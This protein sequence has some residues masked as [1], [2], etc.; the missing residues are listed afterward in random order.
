MATQSNPDDDSDHVR[1]D[2]ESDC[3]HSFNKAG[4]PSNYTSSTSNH[5]L[6]IQEGD[7][8]H[9]GHRS[10]LNEPSKPISEDNRIASDT[11]DVEETEDDEDELMVPSKHLANCQKAR[12]QLTSRNKTENTKAGE[13]HLANIY[14]ERLPKLE[15]PALENTSSP[16]TATLKAMSEILSWTRST[17]SEDLPYPGQQLPTSPVS[18]HPL[19]LS[20]VLSPM[21]NAYSGSAQEQLDILFKDAPSPSPKSVLGS[22]D[23]LELGSDVE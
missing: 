6:T 10:P 14:L 2:I 4:R 8:A 23:W 15:D 21:L 12:E 9:T 13:D 11:K 3:C 19:F 20:P 16:P 5:Q 1:Q 18:P 7:K 22:D 17:V